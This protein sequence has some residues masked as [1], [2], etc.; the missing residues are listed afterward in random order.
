MQPVAAVSLVFTLVVGAILWIQ[1]LRMSFAA[2]S[3][4]GVLAI[5]CPP[6]PLVLLLADHRRRR[7][8]LPL[9]LLVAGLSSIVAL[10]S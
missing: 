10:N 9:L 1:V 4:L 6:I 2:S 7:T 8:L 3:G 5:L